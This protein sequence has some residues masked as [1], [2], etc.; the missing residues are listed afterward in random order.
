MAR[1]YGRPGLHDALQD[2]VGDYRDYRIL[3][4]PP[5]LRALGLKRKISLGPFQRPVF[6][7]LKAMRRLRGTPFDLFGYAKVRGLERQLIGEYRT[8]M[9]SELD[10]LTPDTYER[11]TKLAQLPDV[12]RGYED[13]K[14]ASVERFREQARAIGSPDTR[15]VVLTTK[16]AS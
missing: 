4:H 7:A 1:L 5:V 13:V 11:A 15:P 12:I 10:N 9:E 16:P 3:L 14:L 8:L 2:A 6:T